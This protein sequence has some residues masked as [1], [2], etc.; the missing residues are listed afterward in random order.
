[1]NSTHHLLFH[2]LLLGHFIVSPFQAK[3]Q[4]LPPFV[5]AFAPFIE[6]VGTDVELHPVI[7]GDEPMTYQ[8]RFQGR[9]LPGKTEDFLRLPAVG[10]KLAGTYTLVVRNAAGVSTKD[11]SL[12]VYEP[13]TGTLRARW[14]KPLT[15]K[16]RSW[17][18][19]PKVR[20]LGYPVDNSLFRGSHT[21]NFTTTR[22]E[23]LLAPRLRAEVE[24][25]TCVDLMVELYGPPRLVLN[26]PWHTLLFQ[27]TP[28][29]D[30]KVQDAA[31]G[32]GLAVSAT[33]LPPGL[34][35]NGTEISGEPTKAGLY[36]VS[37][38]ARNEHGA[39]APLAWN[40]EVADLFHPVKEAP[41]ASFAT[42]L[43]L[44]Q[45]LPAP[46]S[47]LRGGLVT[48]KV[49]RSGAISGTLS[50]GPNVRRF[51]GTLKPD[52]MTGNSVL[53]SAVWQ[54]TGLSGIESM[55]LS[56]QQVTE[57]QMETRLITRLR[58]QSD[59]GI[60][61]ISGEQ[62]GPALTA[63][64]PAARACPGR[65][66]FLFRPENGPVNDGVGYMSINISTSWVA[67]GSGTLAN[68]VGMTCSSPLISGAG[69]PG[70]LF[71]RSRKTGDMLI[72]QLAGDPA[73]YVAT[74]P[75]MPFEG[76]LL[77]SLPPGDTSIP[78]GEV[79]DEETLHVSGRRY[80]L[81]A[82]GMSPFA[83]RAFEI[84][85]ED[86]GLILLPNLTARLPIP[87]VYQESFSM[88]ASTGLFTGSYV[89]WTGGNPFDGIIDK[90]KRRTFRYRGMLAPGLHVGEGFGST[91]T[92]PRQW[93]G[94]F[95]YPHDR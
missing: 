57:L 48:A 15:V 50:L 7:V 54:L 58:L 84:D 89:A 10:S 11:F 80:F 30:L 63:L 2:A 9:V 24:T 87:N 95:I 12:T 27:G 23:A 91:A 34:T 51:A 42:L 32:T 93:W 68:G 47:K 60:Y 44:G 86:K 65:Y 1:M 25:G 14:D 74:V 82:L 73:A 55:E 37:F 71:A 61:E 3:A 38:T 8:W 19:A 90:P 45:N 64:S 29:A 83:D 79:M 76:E 13:V 49:Q 28:V 56:L 53:R 31:G 21:P 6:A 41:A 85:P 59:G 22:A 46:I 52:S 92:Y 62:Q 33:G 88:H 35:L 75:E 17:G 18:R 40:V 4:D 66:T 78:P 16:F 39:A 20:W 5:W 67:N 26:K 36:K 72:G 69:L 43:R 77:W 81:P 94:Y 70:F